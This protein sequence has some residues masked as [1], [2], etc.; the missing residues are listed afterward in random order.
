MSLTKVDFK[1][2]DKFQVKPI[3]IYGSKE[4]IIRFLVSVAVID[5]TMFV[6]LYSLIQSLLL[7]S[8]QRGQVNHFTGSKNRKASSPLWP[9]HLPRFGVGKIICSLLARRVDMGRQCFSTCAPESRRLHEV[10]S[11]C[12]L[13]Y[14][15]AQVLRYLTTICDQVTALISKVH[16]ESMI[17]SNTSD[18]Q[19]SESDEDDTDRLFTFEV[20][21]TKEQEEGVTV[22][23][24]FKVC[25]PSILIRLFD[26]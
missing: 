8:R 18:D 24:G 17:W 22:R 21:K 1:V 3:G 4:E 13:V 5:D 16:A 15:S 10:S 25:S 2:L 23:Q 26:D 6:T 14:R 9:V 12:G 7:T 20:A 11:S 19:L